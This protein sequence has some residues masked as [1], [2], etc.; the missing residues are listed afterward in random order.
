MNVNEALSRDITAPGLLVPCIE[1]K[2]VKPIVM[3]NPFTEFQAD[4]APKNGGTFSAAIAYEDSTTRD[5]ALE[6]CDRLM[7]KF[8]TDVEFEFSWWR[9]DF[10][11]DKGIFKAAVE[12]AARSDLIMIS[13]H[14]ARQLPEAVQDWIETWL[15]RRERGTGVLAAMIGIGEDAL[16]GWTPIHVYLR[17][18]AQRANMDYLPQVLDAPQDRLDGSI[19]KIARRAEEVTSLLDSILHRP[20]IASHWGINE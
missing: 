14:A 17:E 16:K 4:E 18:A 9:F 6:T 12:A 1:L 8:W 3:N 2:V 19:E 5:R 15:G 10:L 13:A 20:P 11:R 7:Q